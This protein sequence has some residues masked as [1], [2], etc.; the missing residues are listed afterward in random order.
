ML[1]VQNNPTRTQQQIMDVATG[2]SGSLEPNDYYGFHKL[3][4][5]AQKY[6]VDTYFHDLP[7]M[8]GLRGNVAYSPAVNA[9]LQNAKMLSRPSSSRRT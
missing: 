7:P 2:S 9:L 1:N 4:S 5:I 3:V 8:A 6:G